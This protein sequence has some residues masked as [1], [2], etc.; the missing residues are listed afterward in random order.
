MVWIKGTR[1]PSVVHDNLFSAHKEAERLAEEVA[2]GRRVYVLET[3]G[4]FKVQPP[5]Q[6]KAKGKDA[7]D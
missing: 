4:S 1:G 2:P 5:K 3:I 7:T 6:R